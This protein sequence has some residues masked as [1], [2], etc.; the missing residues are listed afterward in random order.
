MTLAQMLATKIKDAL[1]GDIEKGFDF[2]AIQDP[3]HNYVTVHIYMDE[4]GKQETLLGSFEVAV[5]EI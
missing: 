2:E 5:E 3:D 4:D 1:D